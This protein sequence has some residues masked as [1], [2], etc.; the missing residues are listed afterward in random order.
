MVHISPG[1]TTLIHPCRSPLR[2]SGSPRTSSK[3]RGPAGVQEN[4][5]IRTRPMHN[6]AKSTSAL[7][8][9]KSLGCC[10]TELHFPVVSFWRGVWGYMRANRAGWWGWG[11]TVKLHGENPRSVP[12]LGSEALSN[13]CFGKSNSP[14]SNTSEFFKKK[15]FTLC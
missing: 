14:P 1:I 6:I 7:L 5:A 11:R 15:E 10:S 8:E 3:A 9:K 13:Y 12:K 4:R 2:N